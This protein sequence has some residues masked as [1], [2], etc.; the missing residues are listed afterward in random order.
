MAD[1]GRFYSIHAFFSSKAHQRLLDGRSIWNLGPCFKTATA[2]FDNGSELPVRSLITP[3]CHDLKMLNA[4]ERSCC[5]NSWSTES[6][7][8]IKRL[9]LYI[10]KA[11]VF[12]Y[13]AI[14]N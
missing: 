2:A 1:F 14:D 3:S 6:M 13:S 8:K 12:C 9:W 4:Q 10:A 5:K 11:D 7:S